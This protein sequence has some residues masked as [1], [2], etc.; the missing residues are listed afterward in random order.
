MLFLS[1]HPALSLWKSLP[2]LHTTVKPLHKSNKEEIIHMVRQ[3]A[4]RE[5]FSLEQMGSFTFLSGGHYL[6]SGG[7]WPHFSPPNPSWCTPLKK[8]KNHVM[9][10]KCIRF[11]SITP[12]QSWPNWNQSSGGGMAGGSPFSWST[13]STRDRQPALRGAISCSTSVLLH[14]AFCSLCLVSIVGCITSLFPSIFPVVLQWDGGGSTDVLRSVWETWQMCLCV[15]WISGSK[16]DDP[17]VPC[18]V[19]HPKR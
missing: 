2:V 14:T 3:G 10:P 15:I 13:L 12:Q 6:L 5:A 18:A 17:H 19:L 11:S 7:S 8:K 1:S 4:P 16:C 9:P